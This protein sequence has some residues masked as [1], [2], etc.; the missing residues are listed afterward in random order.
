[1]DIPV[2]VEQVGERKYVARC[3]EPFGLR[4]EGECH[5]DAVTKLGELLRKK[6]AEGARLDTIQLPDPHPLER[7]AGMIDPNDPTDQEYLQAV[8]DY[9][10][11]RDEELEREIG[12]ADD[13]P[14][15]DV[16]DAPAHS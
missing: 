8:A 1:M 16:T 5:Y 11:E 6:L 3:G 15:Q 10:R 2:L 12:G 13:A 14:S 9:R 7:Y 4:A